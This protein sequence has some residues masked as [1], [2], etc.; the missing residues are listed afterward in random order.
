MSGSVREKESVAVEFQEE[1]LGWME[2]PGWFVS[3][4]VHTALLL[5][6]ALV[7]METPST[8][9]LHDL[10]SLP[11]EYAVLEEEPMEEFLE[12]VE[13]NVEVAD[14]EVSEVSQEVTVEV[15]S[16]SVTEE[17]PAAPMI[18]PVGDLLAKRQTLSQQ[19]VGAMESGYALRHNA[20][21]RMRMGT[22]TESERAV[23]LGL[24]WL[25]RHQYPDGSWNYNH[26][27]APGC[28]GKC[29]RPGT[30]MKATNAATAMGI[31]PFLGCGQTH[32]NGK[33]KDSVYRGLDYLCR[34]MKADRKVGG[35][36]FHQAEGTMYA[37][38]LA[39]IC[40]TEAYGMTKDK[41]LMRPSQLA[42]DFIMNAQD[43]AG[44]GWRYQPRQTGDTSV[45]GWQLMA[46]KSG[47]MGYL[48]VSPLAAQNAMRFLDSVQ[49]ESGAY[50]GYVTPGKGP[51]CT[52]IGLLCRMYYGWKQ[53][54]PALKKGV[55]YLSSMGPSQ[56]MYYNYYATQV[57][58]HFGGES[59]RKWNQKMREQLV[60]TQCQ[61]GCEQGS[62]DPAGGHSESG[63]RLY[64]TSL[65]VMT[66]EVYYR[67]SPIYQ[68]QSVEGGLPLE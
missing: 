47:Y 23:A 64:M 45:V 31:L 61:E 57:L 17:E 53:E 5:V 43:P 35:G 59:W 46:L 42:L 9:P 55:E 40:L 21:A 68:S 44:G 67:H 49:S 15:A 66:L 36:S 19:R 63:G 37:H 48:R 39:T 10:V 41:K 12:P 51:A 58:R 29:T 18:V 26:T 2:I 33:Y 7:T 38:G 6:M 65:S 8:T 13:W 3:M 4:M 1:R 22:T 32:R 54:H 20:S 34:N 27:M 30:M 60:A 50:Y 11:E 62:W 14:L 25:A 24:R 56:D 16:A 52:A 28:K